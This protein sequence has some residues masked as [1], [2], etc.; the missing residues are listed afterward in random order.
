MSHPFPIE[1]DWDDLIAWTIL[2]PEFAEAWEKLKGSGIGSEA[3][4]GRVADL[5]RDS[6]WHMSR[7]EEQHATILE[8]AN[9]PAEE[10]D[11]RVAAE[12]LIVATSYMIMGIMLGM[13]TTIRR[14]AEAVLEGEKPVVN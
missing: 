12:L 8:A 13:A 3:S 7:L 6:D 1:L 2:S 14:L 4:T 9:E 10:F 5:I 11:H